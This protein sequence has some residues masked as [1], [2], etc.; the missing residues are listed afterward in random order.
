MTHKKMVLVETEG[1]SESYRVTGSCYLVSKYGWVAV[2][3][4]DSDIIVIS[5]K[6]VFLQC[7]IFCFI[8][9]FF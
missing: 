9:G 8:L 7:L 6:N 2:V 4:L 5:D 1:F 3:M